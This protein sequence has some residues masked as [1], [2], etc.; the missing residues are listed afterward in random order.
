MKNVYN[1]QQI[2][3]II[4]PNHCYDKRKIL[5]MISSVAKIDLTLAR[6]NNAVVIRKWNTTSH[7]TVWLEWEK[8]EKANATLP[9]TIELRILDTNAEKQLS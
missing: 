1:N 2:I 8:I 3:I 5:I 9:L 6:P 4:E 7:L